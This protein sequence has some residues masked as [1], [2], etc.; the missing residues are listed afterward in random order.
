MKK[1]VVLVGCGNIGSRHLQGLIKLQDKVS[2][3][4]VEP[5]IKAQK[6][7][8]SLIHKEKIKNFPVIN[9]FQNISEINIKSDLVIVATNSKGRFD[10]LSSLLDQG[11]KRFLVEKIVCQSKSEYMKL[12]S[13]MKKHKA[14]S[15]VNTPRRYFKSYQKIKKLLS[16]DDLTLTVDAGNLGLGSNAIHILDLFSWFTDNYDIRL[17]GDYLDNEILSNKRGKNFVEF[18]GTLIGK[19]KKNTFISITFHPTSNIPFT[20]MFVSKKTK[21]FLNESDSKIIFNTEKEKLNFKID[22]VSNI[23]D[24]IISDIFKKDSCLLPSL[25]NSFVTHTELFRVFNQ[26]LKKIQHPQS[27]LCPI[28]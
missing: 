12:I 18:S 16:N 13:K 1:N 26:H 6:I 21:I 28:T 3:T 22:Y 25:E 20:L 14:K 24:K 11:H 10:L 27:K 5:Q 7:A 19:S 17:N 23:T 2:I 9:W 8:Q 4:I 15:W